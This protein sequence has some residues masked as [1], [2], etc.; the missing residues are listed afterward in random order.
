MTPDLVLVAAVAENGVIGADGGLPWRVR[1][2]LKRFRAVTMGKPMIM[3]RKTF[4]SIGRVLD[5]RDSIVV[6]RKPDDEMPGNVIVAHTV[7]EAVALGAERAAYRGVSEVCVIGG[8]QIF[9]ETMPA[10]TRLDIT[11][12]ALAPDGDAYFPRIDPAVWAEV[13][14]EALPFDAGDTAAAVNAIY[15]RGI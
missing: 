11:H 4:D 2:D 10:A 12:I 7:P 3:G 8:A 1:F 9:E 15:Q 6:T 14:R 13:L 5:G